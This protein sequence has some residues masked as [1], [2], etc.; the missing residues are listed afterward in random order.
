MTEREEK[1]NR[2]KS[3]CDQGQFM[4][5]S[6]LYRCTNK[7]LELN[8]SYPTSPS[9]VPA[10]RCSHRLSIRYGMMMLWYDTAM[11]D[12]FRRSLGCGFL[13]VLVRRLVSFD[14]LSPPFPVSPVPPFM[15]VFVFV[16]MF[17]FV[18]F[19]LVSVVRLICLMG[20]FRVRPLRPASSA[21]SE[22]RP[23]QISRWRC[24]G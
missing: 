16:F 11:Y 1:V 23:C 6:R 24:N 12:G 4:S 15:F 2:D 13:L 8:V 17:V 14:V 20:W 21:S 3:I 18:C 22:P 9:L 19:L 5:V 10:P 7:V